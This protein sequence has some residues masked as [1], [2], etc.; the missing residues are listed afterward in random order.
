MWGRDDLKKTR[1][2]QEAEQEGRRAGREEV[3][4]EMLQI[5]VSLLLE[6]GIT[7]EEIAQHFKLPIET[8]QQFAFQ[9]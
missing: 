1:A 7:I 5:T 9:K 4:Q 2:Y 6:K 3:R 8:L